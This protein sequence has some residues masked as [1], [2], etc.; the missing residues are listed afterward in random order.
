M[1]R[2]QVSPFLTRIFGKRL[3]LSPRKTIS[4]LDSGIS[5]HGLLSFLILR[6]SLAAQMRGLFRGPRS[7]AAVR[8][9][10]VMRALS[11]GHFTDDG[12]AS[13]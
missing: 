5:I 2:G 3:A 12:Q 9:S 7:M 10:H 11:W 1:G 4:L 8:A 13:A 6:S